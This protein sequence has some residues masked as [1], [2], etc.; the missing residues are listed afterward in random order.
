MKSFYNKLHR[1]VFNLSILL[2]AFA[3]SGNVFAATSTVVDDTPTTRG[4]AIVGSDDKVVPTGGIQI[5][6]GELITNTTLISVSLWASDNRTS[7][8]NLRMSLSFDGQSYGSWQPF[9]S[10]MQVNLPSGDGMKTVY[11]RYMDESGNISQPYYQGVILQSGNSSL[12][13]QLSIYNINVSPN[14]SDG[15]AVIS[16]NTSVPCTSQFR[17]YKNSSSWN[18]YRQVSSQLKTSHSMEIYGLT[19]GT[20]YKFDIRCYDANGNEVKIEAESFTMPK[21][22]TTNKDTQAPVVSLMVNDGSSTTTSPD[23]VLYISAWDDSNGALEMS[24]GDDYTG[25][26]SWQPYSSR[27]NWT[28]PSYAGKRTIYVKV[29]DA[30][31]NVG[32]AQASVTLNVS[33]LTISGLQCTNVSNYSCEIVWNTDKSSSSWVYYGTNYSVNS[34][35]GSNSKSTY[36]SVKLS[37]LKA[38]TTYYYKVVSEDSSGRRVES[39]VYTFTTQPDSVK[40]RTAPTGSIKINNGDSYTQ[41]QSVVLNLTAQDNYTNTSNIQM[42][43]RDDSTQ[44]GNWMNF[45]QSLNFALSYKEGKRTIYVQFRDEAG[46]V[47]KEYSASITLDMTPPTISGVR[48]TN[49]WSDSATIVWSTNEE[50]LAGVEY[51]TSSYYYSGRA[52]NLDVSSDQSSSGVSTRGIAVVPQGTTSAKE[53]SITI[54]GLYANTTYYYQ[55]ISQDLAGNRTVLSGYSFTT[56]SNN[57]YNPWGN[58]GQQQQQY[59]ATYQTDVNWA[60]KDSGATVK[61]SSYNKEGF[62]LTVS[63]PE[64]AIDESML[65]FWE[66]AK[67]PSASSP[68]WIEI[69]FDGV[70]TINSVTV[71]GVILMPVDSYTVECKVN[72]SWVNVAT[73]SGNS[74]TKCESKFNMVNAT[75]IRISVTKASGNVR[76][77]EI[78]A[79][80]K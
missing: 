24:I 53:H 7:T 29:R 76:I 1:V 34:K 67:S 36:H 12:S 59:Q 18:A 79:V 27:I 62:F 30:A 20:T 80:L 32:Q 17:H 37:G 51:G 69:T 11:V 39:Q 43:M 70:K 3:V 13:S 52:G 46:N 28:T 15:S 50:C 45:S 40:D 38:N 66:S 47:S 64:C 73:V 63:K 74:N 71:S 58:S 26:T 5:N 33:N 78:E 10:Q 61:A 4:I 44:Y 23:L 25:F 21:S 56:S 31:G 8:N 72:G 41:Y 9:I 48:V 54:S 16:W 57:S 75:A 22:A 6:N 55:V 35:K 42:R 68:Q 65:T 19:A 60:S 2:L 77:S 49:V 14:V